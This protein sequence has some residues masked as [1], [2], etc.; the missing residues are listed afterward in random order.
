MSGLGGD[1]ASSLGLVA[2][3]VSTMSHLT[4]HWLHCRWTAS[5]SHSFPRLSCMSLL[6]TQMV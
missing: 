2:P 4:S 1:I 6:S 5:V 3:D